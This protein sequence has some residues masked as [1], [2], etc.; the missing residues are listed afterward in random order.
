VKCF[1]TSNFTPAQSFF[2]AGQAGQA[3]HFTWQ[4]QQPVS[5]NLIIFAQILPDLA[6]E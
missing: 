2:L 4:A 6:S 5:L 3:S 1:R